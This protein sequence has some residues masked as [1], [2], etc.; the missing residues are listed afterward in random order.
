MATLTLKS[1]SYDGRYMQLVC[2]STSNG[3]AKNSSTVKWTLSTVGGSVPCY[4]TGATTVTINGT[5]VY[6][7][8]RTA[9]TTNAF[10]AAIG[11][12][13]GSITVPHNSDGTKS[14]SVSLSTAIYT[15]TVTT[16][17]GTLTLDAIPRYATV[18]H[19]MKS[20]TET[21]ITMNWSSDST[22]DYL[23]YS[24]DNGTKWTG[25]DVADGKSG[26]YTISGLT[27]YTTYNIKTRIRRKDSQLTT[28]SF[29]ASI[30][31]YKYPHCTGAPN[32]IVGEELAL[33]FY[34]P[35]NRTFNFTITGNGKEIYTWT[36]VKGTEYRGV[37]GEPAVTNLYNSIP[38]AVSAK[39]SVT[40]TYGS[41]QKVTQGGTYT[42]NEDEC[43]PTFSTFTYYDANQS[44]VAVTGNDQVIVQGLS[45][46]AVRIPSANKMVARHAAT[47][48]GYYLITHD[49]TANVA[50][51][52]GDI[53]QTVGATNYAGSQTVAVRAY[54][55][56]NLS[57]SP[58]K[59]LLLCQY[60][61]PV[62][63]ATAKRLNNFE[64]E[65]TLTVSG[66]F[67]P[68]KVGGTIKNGVN[69]AR[70]RYK[71]NGGEWSSYAPL[72]V[73]VSGEKFTCADITLN[74][75]NSKA[76][77]FEVVVTDKFGTSG[78]STATVNVDV[79]IPI[80]MISSNKKKCYINGEEVA[81]VNSVQT[82]N[83]A[84]PTMAE[85]I[86]KVYP[87]GAESYEAEETKR[88]NCK[89]RMAEEIKNMALVVGDPS[90]VNTVNTPE[91]AASSILLTEKLVESARA[92]GEKIYL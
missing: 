1:A 29:A 38:S 27:E 43:K 2:T 71:E 78:T 88:E 47:P 21:T 4:S 7:K 57:V 12:T 25:V 83:D 51:T 32:F 70:Y 13:S 80:F 87:V 79:G 73:T 10:P 84:V 66:Q 92:D 3:A 62:I 20:R 6:S 75:D 30:T 65:T 64:D 41:V 22:V 54:D 14:I 23:W 52:S 50:Y 16:K 49:K 69:S 72:P 76:F 18:T 82:V 46:I 55:S 40:V 86:D 35:L 17:S 91:C 28:D 58:F 5:V 37:D 31:T 19:S 63:N 8:A 36:G 90:Y 53:N 59:E 9:Y 44:V 89:D 24:T 56:R 85:I 74:L 81:T 33:Q 68:V 77:A 42:V 11:S 48:Q 67:A 34:N 61:K 39:Y 60:A 15:K 45:T 26:T